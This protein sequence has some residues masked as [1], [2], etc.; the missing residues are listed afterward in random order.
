MSKCYAID[1]DSFSLAFIQYDFIP[2]LLE[3]LI[4]ANLYDRYLHLLA[5][6]A[7][8]TCFALRTRVVP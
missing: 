5:F 8:R 7:S 2:H 6:P 3:Q 1:L 4:Q